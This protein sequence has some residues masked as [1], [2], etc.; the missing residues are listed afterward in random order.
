MGEEKEKRGFPESFGNLSLF[1]VLHRKV[2]GGGEGTDVTQ[3]VLLL[4][5]GTSQ[6]GRGSTRE[7]RTGQPASTSAAKHFA[8]QA[9]LQ[10]YLSA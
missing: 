3:T 9:L 6:L 1:W 8:F 10:S 2:L 7:Q 4:Y 5:P